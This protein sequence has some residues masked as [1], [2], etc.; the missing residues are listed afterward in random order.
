MNVAEF[1]Q[2]VISLSDR[3]FPMVSRMLGGRINAEDAIQEIMIRLWDKRR[4]LKKH[5]NVPGFVFL[6][7][8]NYCLDQLKKAKPDF[9]DTAGLHNACDTDKYGTD[10]LEWKELKI[11]IGRIV[12]S[13]PDQQQKIITMRDLDGLEFQEIAVMTNLKVEHIRVLLSRARKQVALELKKIYSYEG[14]H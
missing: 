5:P 7:A 2:Q 4:Q 8:R 14:K 6:T 1:K 3:L 13:L 11:L 12:Q 10:D 9:D